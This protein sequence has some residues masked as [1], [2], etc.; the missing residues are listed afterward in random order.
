[1]NKT[2][3]R[4]TQHSRPCVP[5]EDLLTYKGELYRKKV[6]LKEKRIESRAQM[7]RDSVKVN[8]MS[9][10]IVE[11]RYIMRGETTEDR[12]TRP[13]GSIKQSTLQDAFHDLT[14]H[15]NIGAAS[16]HS[17]HSNSTGGISAS[18]PPASLSSSFVNAR[19]G[20]EF[21]SHVD[22]FDPAGLEDLGDDPTYEALSDD[23]R[24][25]GGSSHARPLK[26][27]Q[28]SLYS[29][30]KKWDERRQLKIK[31]DQE[32][33]LHAEMQECSFKPNLPGSLSLAVEGER[34]FETQSHVTNGSDS[35]SRSGTVP[36]A[37]RNALWMRRR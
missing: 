15:P 29:R 16:A 12:L 8:P 10:R 7:M 34:D 18:A 33:K 32:R 35:S 37:D 22:F 6:Q 1:M 24:D 13:I 5:V 14:F 23:S 4:I 25:G 26:S 19:D 31:F 9:Q 21:G 11:E 17:N 36:I 3:E 20:F 27:K 2:T 28:P 30:A